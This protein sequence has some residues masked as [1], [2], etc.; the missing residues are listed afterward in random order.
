MRAKLNPGVE[1]QRQFHAYEVYRDLGHGRSRRQVA[2]LVEASAVTVCKWA[3]L[4][5]WDER[6]A[7]HGA[8]IEERKE[9]GALLPSEGPVAEKLLHML[10]QAEALIDSAFSKGRDGK[11]HANTLELKSVE[12]LS[13]LISEYRKLLEAYG[14]VA[15][16]Y[17]P[18]KKGVERKMDVK[19][20]NIYMGESGQ[21]ERIN[22]L[23]GITNGNV[24]GGNKG[25]T[26]NVQDADFTDVPGQGNEDGHGRD[27]VSGSPAGSNGGD[28][29]TMRES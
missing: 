15:A 1:R 10:G 9:V 6:V 26:G 29:E 11:L 24:P 25:T 5:N 12:D 18:A 2:K 22:M 17:I 7:Q 13:R 28:E 19:Q 4:Y 20:F 14:K 8:L 21:Q 16:P 3:K 27:G 23:K